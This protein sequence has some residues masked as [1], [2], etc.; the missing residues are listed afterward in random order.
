MCCKAFFRRNA[1][2]GLES[3]Q[4]RYSTENCTINMRTRRDCSY[5]RLKKCFEVGMK[6]ELILTDDVK[7]MKRE[8]LHANRQLTLVQRQEFLK[9]DDLI[10]IRNLANLY[11]EYCR[12]PIMTYEKREYDMIC[13]QPLKTRIKFQHYVE[14]YQMHRLSVEKFLKFVPEMQQFSCEEQKLLS[15]NNI[16]YLMR[17]N[18]IEVLTDS[19]PSWGAIHL[20]LEI[21]Y[22]KSLI[23]ETD[24]YL[25]QLKS[26][27]SDPRCTQLLLIVLFF[28]T[29]NNQSC[30][31]NTLTLFKIQEKYTQILWMYLLQY[32]GEV[33]AYQKFS[34]IIRYCVHLQTIHHLIESKKKDTQWQEYFIS[35]Q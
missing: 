2:F 18:S 13:H 5:C 29:S 32:Y 11:E 20:L 9:E 12:L 35:F 30:R 23:E 17:V 28:S 26:N 19:F 15:A 10:Y 3:Y 4:C 16:R 31:L 33:L 25:R 24:Y 22:G 14:S 7:R 34:A 1:L 8:K 21:I 6:K 27:L